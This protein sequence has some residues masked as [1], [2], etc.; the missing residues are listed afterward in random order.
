[1]AALENS[2]GYTE[3]LQL[4]IETS[5]VLHCVDLG[6]RGNEPLVVVIVA[7]APGVDPPG[8]RGII[9]INAIGCPSRRRPE[10]FGVRLRAAL[11]GSPCHEKER[12]GDWLVSVEGFGYAAG[13]VRTC[14]CSGPLR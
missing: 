6:S 2:S 9:I 4:E 8:L 5:C 10:R 7:V 3:Y 13:L 1:M 12:W 14:Q 11:V